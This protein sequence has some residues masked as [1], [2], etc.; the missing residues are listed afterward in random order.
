MIISQSIQITTDQTGKNIV[1]ADVSLNGRGTSIDFFRGFT[2]FL[3]IGESTKIYE[4]FK[5]VYCRQDE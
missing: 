2:K 4:H 5:N 3:L 1:S